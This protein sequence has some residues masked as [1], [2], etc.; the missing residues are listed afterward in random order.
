MTPAEDK[1][2]A[3]EAEIETRLSDSVWQAGGCVSWYQDENGR[4]TTLWP[5]TVREYQQLM[6]KSGLEQYRLIA[7]E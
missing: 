3:F 7:P 6:A 4:N 2:A 1:Q 5:G